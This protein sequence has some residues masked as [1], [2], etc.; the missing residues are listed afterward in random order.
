MCKWLVAFIAAVVVC[1]SAS[2]QAEKRVALVIG[3]SS[4]ATSRLANPAND[5][6]LMAETLRG[7]GFTLVGEGA[8][9]ISTRLASTLLFR[10]SARVQ[11]ADVALFYYAGHGVQVR[12]S[13]YLVPVAANPTR[14]ADVI[15]RWSIPARAAARW[16]ALARGSISSSSTPAATILSVARPSIEQRAALRRCTAPEGTLI[17]FATQ[18][19][20]VALD[21]RR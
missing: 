19:G 12:G 3:N 1:S 21:G 20:N 16:K 7:L 2:A 15:S 5:A 9:S 14:E 18:P 10:V 11:G 4:Y 6:R 17:S 8:N 13:N